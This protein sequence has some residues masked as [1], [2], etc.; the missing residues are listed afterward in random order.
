M[1][2]RF[3][4]N[5][6]VPRDPAVEAWFA[7]RNNALG[8]IARTWFEHMRQCGSEVVE[9]VHDGWAVACVEDLP[10]AYVST[11]TKHVNVGFFMGAFLPDPSA[12]L[13]GTGKRMRHVKL[14]P[15]EQTD[16]SG[17][18]ALIDAAYRDARNFVAE[19]PPF[20]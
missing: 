4:L 7:E 13:Q 2:E 15:G 6:A 9:L 10:F 1:E 18:A 20:G 11:F 12:L 16:A 19:E 5:G 8:A 17:L 3:R 14:F